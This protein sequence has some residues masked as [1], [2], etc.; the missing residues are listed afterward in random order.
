MTI[1]L[2]VAVPLAPG[3]ELSPTPVTV[4]LKRS[5]TLPSSR[6]NTSFVFPVYIL[7]IL[8]PPAGCELCVLRPR[9][10]PS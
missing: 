3:I 9:A 8:D 1:R 4:S 10:I 6:K 5:R 2:F 7:C